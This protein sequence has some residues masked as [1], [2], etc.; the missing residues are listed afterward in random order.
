NELYFSYDSVVGGTRPKL[1][2]IV[3]V[4]ASKQISIGGF[5]VIKVSVLSSEWDDAHQQAHYEASDRISSC[6]T[7]VGM[8]TSFHGCNG[9]INENILFTIN[10]LEADFVPSRGD[11]VTAEVVNNELN[12]KQAQNIKPLRKCEKE[13]TKDKNGITVS[14]KT[15]FGN[16]D[17]GDMKKITI[18]LRNQGSTAQ[19]FQRCHLTAK[20][21]QFEI[22]SVMLLK[23]HSVMKE[24]ESEDIKGRV[25]NLHP[26]MSVGNEEQLLVLTFNEFRIGRY[27]RANVVHPYQSLVDS[28]MEYSRQNRYGYSQYKNSKSANRNLIPGEKPNNLNKS[29]KHFMKSEFEK[30]YADQISEEL[31]KGD[32]VEKVHVELS[33]TVIKS[34]GAKWIVKAFNYIRGKKDITKVEFSM[35]GKILYLPNRLPQ[36]N[37]PEALRDCILEYKDKLEENFPELTQELDINNYVKRFHTLLYLEEI[38]MDIDIR[39][40]DLNRVLLRPVGEFLALKVPGLAEGR[41]SVLIGDKVIAPIRRCHQAAEFALNLGENVLFPRTLLPKLSRIIDWKQEVEPDIQPVAGLNKKSKSFQSLQFFNCNLNKRQKSAVHRIMQGQS[42]PLPYILFGPPGT[43]KTI[44][45]VETMLQILIKIPSS[46]ILA[47]APSNSAADLIAERLHLSGLIRTSDMVRLN[48][49]QRD[50]E[51]L[52]GNVTPYCS[53]G[54]DLI[55]ISH[56]RIIVCTCVTAG[57][58]YSQGIKADHF[59]HIFI[60]EL[61]PVLTSRYAKKYGLGTLLPREINYDATL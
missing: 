29:V 20:N 55:L 27:L 15:N 48:A 50:T 34:L 58:L 35:F 57:L 56:Y 36:Y 5:N 41:P 30:W 45:L 13:G 16:V 25:V 18:W 10:D 12:Q 31:Q 39:E 7:V 19:S 9:F 44:T 60:D 42:R 3:N 26:G 17:I 49:L 43:G 4:L 28:G 33:L 40:F 21:S 14:A 51:N 61:G 46:R 52:S 38:Q 8:V 2:D 1:G 59:S 47:C 24:Q 54:E 11:F 32:D 53:V 6:E 23:E 22:D 37:V